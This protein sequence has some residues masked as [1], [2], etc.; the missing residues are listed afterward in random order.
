[1]EL[2]AELKARTA[3]L[4]FAL[5][6]TFSAKWV[7]LWVNNVLLVSEVKRRRIEGFSPSFHSFHYT[8]GV[9]WEVAVD[10][11]SICNLVVTAGLLQPC[12]QEGEIG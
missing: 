9:G 12:Q 6:C 5:L 2:I 11:L 10:N 1:M 7:A 4:Y 3:A 8:A